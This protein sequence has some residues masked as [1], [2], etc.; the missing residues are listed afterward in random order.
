MW[1]CLIHHEG[2]SLLDPS[3]NYPLID[4]V[5][6]ANTHQD[7]QPVMNLPLV[8]TYPSSICGHPPSWRLSSHSNM[9]LILCCKRLIVVCSMFFSMDS[10]QPIKSYHEKKCIGIINDL[11]ITH[12]HA[13][14]CAFKLQ[15]R[16][17][18]SQS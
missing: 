5:H 8:E 3:E 2:F 18:H 10:S 12:I 11:F 4:C 9:H 16:W 13:V 15:N 17:S 1:C 14:K 7:C 6:R